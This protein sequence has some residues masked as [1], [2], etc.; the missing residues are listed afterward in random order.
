MTRGAFAGVV[1]QNDLAHLRFA[2]L[3]SRFHFFREM[4]PDF[5]GQRIG[6]QRASRYLSITLAI[7]A[8][9]FVAW[10]VR[11]LGSNRGSPFSRV[12]CQP[13]ALFRPDGGF[14]SEHSSKTRWR[15]L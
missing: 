1:F 2:V 8:W 4:L 7:S 13:R 3:D 12:I 9:N 14:R 6:F 10:T 5:T 11:V 15:V